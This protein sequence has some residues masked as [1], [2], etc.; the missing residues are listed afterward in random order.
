[1]KQPG[2]AVALAER[3]RVKTQEEKTL[4]DNS[5][6][7]RR[8]GRHWK[9]IGLASF[10][11]IVVLAD[12]LPTV[13]VVLGWLLGLTILGILAFRLFRNL[14]NRMLWWVRNRLMG[15]FTFV[16]VIPLLLILGMALLVG[17]I[18]A[19][20]LAAGYL[21]S[22]LKN[23]EREL[24]WIHT[25]LATRIPSPANP[26][27]ESRGS[28]LFQAESGKFPKLAAH[29]LRRGE[30]GDFEIAGAYDPQSV[31]ANLESW[32]LDEWLGDQ[33][34]FQG[35]IE[36]GETSLMMALGRLAP[37]GEY[38]LSVAAPLDEHIEQRLLDEHSIYSVLVGA[39]SSNVTVSNSG[40]SVTLGGNDEEMR[41]S[42]SDV[43]RRIS[44]RKTQAGEDP[45]TMISWLAFLQ[46]GK[47][48]SVEEDLAAVA[49]IDVPLEVLYTTYI[50][51]SA[52]IG[53]ILI[54][55]ILI[56]LGL[57]F[58][59][60]VVSIIIG[61]TLS[62]R[63]T[64]SV[65]DMY[66]GTLALQTGDFDHKIPE[67]R[68][69]QLGLLAKSFNEMSGAIT[70]LMEEVTEKK[71]LEQE[72]EIAREVQATLFPKQLPKPRG[73]SLFGGC[74]PALVVSGDYYDFILEDEARLHIVLADIS[75]KGISAALLMANLQAAMRNQLLSV[76][77]QNVRELEANLARVMEELNRQIYLNSPAEKY[78]TLF[79]GRFDADTRQFS[80]C[81]AGHLPPMLIHNGDLVRLETGGTVVGL[82]E[83][84]SYEAS[85]IDLPA[86]SILA[87]FTD[88][89]TEAVN[90]GE[91]DYGEERLIAALRE[92]RHFTAEGIY[93]HV[94]D[95]V[96][97]WQGD[98]K[99]HDDITLIIGKVD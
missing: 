60:E 78:A 81:N 12:W 14:K 2:R 83:Q 41:E 61:L 21:E 96:Q 86:G 53:M 33:S 11:L 8:I 57:F 77:Q 19:G 56:L 59:A 45:R 52:E 72:L 34:F 28:A 66:Q 27:L 49:V 47:S 98:L 84:A 80:Y 22:S 7:V 90:K 79:M 1:M 42:E 26:E 10:A 92:K 85:T 13:I 44:D 51:G 69:D 40:I 58:L 62:R 99:Q 50:A 29:V 87:I 25:E 93:D 55:L 39:G 97:Q 3:S 70:R 88:G 74:S 54:G 38:Y 82:F 71:R 31:T 95:Q 94:I 75:G 73:L 36:A 18:L 63:I 5:S 9:W 68:Q 91:E 32:P 76:K 37:G 23:Y 24:A 48:T 65:H 17:Y 30:G 89:V 43:G 6:A 67:R 16:G 46:R 4:S 35:I 20:Q 64:Q 15:A